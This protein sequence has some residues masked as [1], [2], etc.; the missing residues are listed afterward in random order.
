M[1]TRCLTPVALLLS[2][3]CACAVPADRPAAA[4]RPDRPDTT[5]EVG[6]RRSAGPAPLI[7]PEK[8]DTTWEVPAGKTAT[9]R[10]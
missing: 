10:R 9:P 1:K 2:A 3:L 4:A 5:W 6:G 7:K 8:P